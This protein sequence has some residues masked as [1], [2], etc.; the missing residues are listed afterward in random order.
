MANHRMLIIDDS[1]TIHAL[2]ESVIFRDSDF[3][4][5]GAAWSVR[6][7]RQ[8]MTDLFPTVITLDLAM[9]GVNG[10]DI[11]DELVKEK[12]AP[13][14]GLSSLTTAVGAARDDV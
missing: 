2:R 7:T 14:L 11:L 6:S 8:M 4:V 1:L 10:I 9:P 13:I 3:S 12:Y 5:V